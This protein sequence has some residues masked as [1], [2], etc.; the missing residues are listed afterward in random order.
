MDCYNKAKMYISLQAWIETGMGTAD[1]IVDAPFQ[2]PEYAPYV[3]AELLKKT[4]IKQI[5]FRV[6]E[7]IGEDLIKQN[8]P[9]PRRSIWWRILSK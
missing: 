8:E 2:N 5:P 7:R 9:I 4:P 3:V 1:L 6:L